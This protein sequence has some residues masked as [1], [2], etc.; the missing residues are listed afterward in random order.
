MVFAPDEDIVLLTEYKNDQTTIKVLDLR[1]SKFVWSFLLS[2]T[3]WDSNGY[4]SPSQKA[5]YANGLTQDQILEFSTGRV[6]LDFREWKN[7]PEFEEMD[8]AHMRFHF[9]HT[10]SKFITFW[11]V[12]S[13]GNGQMQVTVWKPKKALE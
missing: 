5:V 6:L 8:T 2:S 3:R 9:A 11:P 7:R 12:K 13:K 10:S 4:V 1:N